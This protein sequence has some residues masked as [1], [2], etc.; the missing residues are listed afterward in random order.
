MCVYTIK[1]KTRRDDSHSFVAAALSSPA[2]A[3]AGFPGEQSFR[4]ARHEAWCP[5]SRKRKGMV[6][7]AAAAPVGFS[8]SG[9]NL[10]FLVVQDA[11]HLLPTDQ[12][13]TAL[14]MI[15]AFVEGEPLAGGC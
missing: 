11:G 9:G 14:E 7:S 4:A 6:S 15:M 3:V 1:R 10:T 8:R 12:P 5:K 13:T 2:K